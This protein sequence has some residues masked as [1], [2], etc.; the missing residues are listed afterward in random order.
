MDTVR[1]VPLPSVLVQGGGYS[2]SLRP[3]S[4]L[5]APK[6]DPPQTLEVVDAEASAWKETQ[7]T[8]GKIATSDSKL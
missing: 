3:S 2:T 4:V 5:S 1:F 8:L 7:K 6:T